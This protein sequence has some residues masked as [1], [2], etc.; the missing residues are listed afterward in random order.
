[1]LRYGESG[2]GLA[3][4]WRPELDWLRMAPPPGTGPIRVIAPALLCPLLMFG[5]ALPLS[6]VNPRA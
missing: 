3:A 5:V 1:M 6:L 4:A 2:T